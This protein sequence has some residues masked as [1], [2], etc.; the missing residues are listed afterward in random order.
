MNTKTRSL[1]LCISLILLLILSLVAI[2]NIGGLA[3]PK[4]EAYADTTEVSNAAEFVSVTPAS[5]G[6]CVG[7][8]VFIFVILELLATCLYVIIRYGFFKGF[9]E[10]CKLT[11]ASDKLGLL[12]L[13]GVCVSQAI[14][15]FALIVL[16]LHQCAASIISFIFATII[17]LAFIYF[18]SKDK[19][20]LD[21]C[22]K[23]CAEIKEK[24]NNKRNHV[25]PKQEEFS[26]IMHGAKLGEEIRARELE[27]IKAEDTASLEA[28]AQTEAEAE[29]EYESEKEDTIAEIEAKE[30]A[31]EAL[32]LKDSLVLAKAT[33]SSHTFSKKFIADY[34]RTK[35]IVEVN[36]RENYTKTGLP[37]ADTH[38]VDGKD[39]KK[40]FTYVYETEGSVILLAKM[41]S[42]YAE[43]LQEKHSQINLSAFPK[44]KNT[45]YS[46][47]LDDTY[48]AKE[49]EGILDELI[50]EVKEDAGMSLKESIALAK[51][52]TS[53]SFSKKYV[54]DYLQD[55]ENVE[56]NTRENYTKTG[57]PLADTHYVEKDGKK[58]CFAYIYEI[59]GSIILLGKMKTK[60]AN[61]L[62]KKHPNVTL[63]AFPKQADTWYSLIIDDTYSKEDFDKIIDDLIADA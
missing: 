34:L 55:K 14:F 18:F 8:I 22:A 29:A 62:K 15:L 12:T 59:E 5:H 53:H 24:I 60:Y 30:K 52:N 28:I 37:L 10:K 27:Q 32:T 48:T 43:K 31:H 7:W 39:G 61:A 21:I 26:I 56:V 25:D 2:Q 19:G 20:I 57:L 4:Q 9:I 38:Y 47:I 50:G 17:M 35:D 58:I 46:L 63:S 33:S 54:C 23:E 6:F 49:V 42:K 11:R 13:I 36:E 40:C 44:Q 41:D 45:W 1:F 16:C 51:A 3:N